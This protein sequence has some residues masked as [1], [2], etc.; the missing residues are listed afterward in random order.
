MVDFLRRQEGEMEERAF[1]NRNVDRVAAPEYLMAAATMDKFGL[2]KQPTELERQ[3]GL[4]LLKYNMNKGLSSAVTQFRQGDRAKEI[5]D[6][7]RKR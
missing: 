7:V 4:A 2:F 5:S 1:M 3:E 6:A